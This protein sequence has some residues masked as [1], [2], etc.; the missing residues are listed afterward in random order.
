M[1]PCLWQQVHRTHM[2]D[3]KAGF[4]NKKIPSTSRTKLPRH[5]ASHRLFAAACHQ[6]S[7][8][9]SGLAHRQTAACV[10]QKSHRHPS[11]VWQTQSVTNFFCVTPHTAKSRK[12]FKVVHK[13]RSK[14]NCHRQLRW[15]TY[16]HSKQNHRMFGVRRD[17]WGSPSPTL[18]TKQGHLQQAAQDLVQAGLQYLQRRGVH[19][20]PGQPVPVLRHPQR[21]E[22]LP[23]VQTELPMLQFVP[24]TGQKL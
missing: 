17:L 24:V 22:V 7:T 16:L 19:S 11:R 8:S 3:N 10:N 18:L 6:S 14:N 9:C 13:T 2:S 15:P 20:L 4:A 23:R 12:R 21:E 5:P 1:T